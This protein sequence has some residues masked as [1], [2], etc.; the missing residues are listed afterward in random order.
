MKSVFFLF[1]GGTNYFI[2]NYVFNRLLF[3][4]DIYEE[5]NRL[6]RRNAHFQSA[7]F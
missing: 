6:L 7:K 4:S 3:W 1:F 5:L 2:I